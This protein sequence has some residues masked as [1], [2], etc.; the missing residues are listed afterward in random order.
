MNFLDADVQPL[1]AHGRS[2]AR[3]IVQFVPFKSVAGAV[4][5]CVSVCASVCLCVRLCVCV[6]V[7]VWVCGCVGVCVGVCV[8]VWQRLFRFDWHLA[9][10]R[11]ISLA[12]THSLT[13][14]HTNTHTHTHTLSLDLSRPLSTSLP[15]SLWEQPV[16]R[17][18]GCTGGAG[19]CGVGRGPSAV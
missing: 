4:C 5:V 17:A 6:S 12:H 16:Q 1:V 13:H 8:C 9:T 18:P 15:L 14:S 3:D 19:G 10:L 11:C 2:A 7:C